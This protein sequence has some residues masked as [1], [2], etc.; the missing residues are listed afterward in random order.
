MTDR[1]RTIVGATLRRTTPDNPV[2]VAA[3]VSQAVGH[4]RENPISRVPRPFQGR[5]TVVT[6]EVK[7]PYAF[8][9]PRP[10]GMGHPAIRWTESLRGS[11]DPLEGAEKGFSVQ[12]RY[13]W[14]GK[15]PSALSRLF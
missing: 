15:P 14:G 3:C 1:N 10:E 11:P 4:S 5:G 2:L 7:P 12:R 13:V 9:P 6:I 8:S